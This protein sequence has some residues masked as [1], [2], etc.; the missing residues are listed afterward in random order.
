VSE[1]AGTILKYDRQLIHAC[2]GSVDT[3]MSAGE[4]PDDVKRGLQQTAQ[5][6]R[7]QPI[8]IANVIAFLLSDEASFVT[9]AVYNVDGGWLC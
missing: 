6:R 9:G 8:E 5:K 4:N 1:I 7:A 3:P 2:I